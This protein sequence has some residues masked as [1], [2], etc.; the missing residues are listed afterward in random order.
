VA[1]LVASSGVADLPTPYTALWQ[2]ALNQHDLG[3]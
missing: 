3:A 2:P 1:W